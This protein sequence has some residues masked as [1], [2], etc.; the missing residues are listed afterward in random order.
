MSFLSSI[1]DD[2]F[3]IKFTYKGYNVKIDKAEERGGSYVATY[4]PA[5]PLYAEKCY[6]V[7]ILSSADYKAYVDVANDYIDSMHLP[8]TVTEN[9]SSGILG[10]KNI[11]SSTKIK[12]HDLVLRARQYVDANL[13]DVP[14][15]NMEE[16]IRYVSN[17]G[18]NFETLKSIKY[19]NR[20]S[21][22]N[23]I[24]IAGDN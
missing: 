4:K 19:V 8:Q 6:L 12:V 7:G 15:I 10:L 23:T 18:L 11:F 9:L 1:P 2:T 3:P 16:Y 13:P 14:E 5:D 24:S 21:N 20:K 22:I 17:S